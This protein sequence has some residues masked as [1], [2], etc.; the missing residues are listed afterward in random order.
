MNI[1]LPLDQMTVAEKFE[2]FQL[3]WEDLCLHQ[4][5]LPVPEF[6]MAALRKRE[7]AQARGESISLEEATLRVQA[8]MGW[9]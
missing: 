2:L 4:D 6:Q 1:T 8:M 7:R 5:E 3:I 9:D